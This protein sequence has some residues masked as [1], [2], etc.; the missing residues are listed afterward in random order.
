MKIENVYLNAFSVPTNKDSALPKF[1]DLPVDEMNFGNLRVEKIPGVTTASNTFKKCY[2][3]FKCP[4]VILPTL[5]VI[6]E[7]SPHNLNYSSHTSG[8]CQYTP[9]T[10]QLL[11]YGT[12]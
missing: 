6:L 7:Y 2:Y 3:N 9:F 5:S 1:L 4:S 12:S 10:F 8:I 11:F